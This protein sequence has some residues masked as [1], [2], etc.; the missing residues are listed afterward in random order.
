LA[1]VTFKRSLFNA[2]KRNSAGRFAIAAARSVELTLRGEPTWVRYDRETG[3]WLHSGSSGCLVLAEP[4][5]VGLRGWE[6]L[7]RE[8][9]LRDYTPQEGDV[10]V[11]V[12]AGVGTETLFMSRL[13]GDTGRVIAIEAH[14]TTFAMLRRMA[15]SNCLGNVTAV[16]A[17]AMDSPGTVTISDEDISQTQANRVGGTGGVAVRAITLDDMLSELGISEV[18]LLKMNIEG[19]ETA[20]IHGASRMLAVTQ[21]GA[22]GCHDFLADETGDES[23]R[24]MK[25]VSTVLQGAGFDVVRRDDHR[26]WAAGYLYASR[27]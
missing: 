3:G 21:H 6:S 12:G 8:I 4:R 20:A 27:S 19:A 13:V 1:A 15:D 16:Q 9:F 10:V 5:G 7:N 2:L 14:P 11:E 22:I 17:A 24:T 25:D 23:Y 26:P 18:A